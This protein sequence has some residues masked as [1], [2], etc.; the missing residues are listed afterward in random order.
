M[1]LSL[2]SVLVLLKTIHLVVMPPSVL[3]VPLPVLRLLVVP[4]LVLLKPLRWLIASSL[5][6][7]LPL[8]LRPLLG[9][10]N[11]PSAVLLSVDLLMMPPAVL[12][13]PL[14]LQRLH[15]QAD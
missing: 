4:P 2:S 11:I 13:F 6:I 7:L 14:L 8:R 10:L 5:V 15:L 9:L 12:L 3:L 1:L